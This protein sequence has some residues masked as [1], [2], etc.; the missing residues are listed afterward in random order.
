MRQTGRAQ[1]RQENQRLVV[2]VVSPPPPVCPHLAAP[3]IPVPSSFTS[4]HGCHP[5][6]SAPSSFGCQALVA[7]CVCLCSSDCESREVLT[8]LCQGET[9]TNVCYHC[10]THC[11]HSLILFH[12]LSSSF[13][14][15]L[16]GS[17]SVVLLRTSCLVFFDP[18]LNANLLCVL[19]PVAL[20][21]LIYYYYLPSSPQTAA[22][23]VLP[24]TV[25]SAVLTPGRAAGL[26][27]SASSTTESTSAVG[28]SSRTAGSSQRRTVSQS[29]PG[30]MHE[31]LN[32]TA[33]RTGSKDRLASSVLG[34]IA[35]SA[36]G[37]CCW[38]PSTTN[39][40]MPTWW[41]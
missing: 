30:K 11:G 9:F 17:F 39:P 1:L 8:L 10:P 2:P 5:E 37:A 23:A 12:T 33:V 34:A 15:D 24:R 20:F 4:L 31:M 38:A 19:T 16:C 36:A 22:G 26:G 21:F 18:L 41:R 25:S 35:F 40:S 28:P 7:N 14:C 13:S 27:R 29:K 32:V 3:A 6:P